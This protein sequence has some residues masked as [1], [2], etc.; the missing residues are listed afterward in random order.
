[1]QIHT[2]EPDRPDNWPEALRAML[3][4]S[5]QWSEPWFNERPGRGATYDRLH[6]FL[7]PELQRY[8]VRGWHCTRLRDT[9]L[10]AI[11]TEGLQVLSEDLVLRRIEAARAAHELTD[12]VASRLRAGHQAGQR[13]RNGQLWFGFSRDLPGEP[14]ISRLV[15]HWGGEA[16]YWTHEDD[17]RIALVL[18]RLGRPTIIDAWV[19]VSGLRTPLQLVDMMCQADLQSAG[20][21]ERGDVGSFEAYSTEPVPAGN[22]IAIDQYPG[23]A[24]EQRTRCRGWKKPLK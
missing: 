19:P 12:E 14:A 23:A 1:M 20:L 11:R 22:I 17:E 9:E 3:V 15:R 18:Q 13:F 6:A 7:T 2:L 21:L 16:M 8:A 4:N 10:Q 24:F 5:R